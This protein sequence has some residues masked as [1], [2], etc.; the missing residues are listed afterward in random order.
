MS[1]KIVKRNIIIK[2]KKAYFDYTFIDTYTAGIILT[3]TEIKSIRN[4]NASLVDTFCYIK[5]KGLWMKNSYI[6][7]Y[8]KH[9]YVSHDERRL[10]KLLLNKREIKKL[11]SESKVP[12]ITI[13]P[14]KMFINDRGLCK[15]E[16]ALCKGN[17]EYDKR[18]IKK[19]K[20]SKREID[21]LIKSF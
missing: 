2:N 9:G 5:D 11:E 20:D 14:I 7:Q 4:G 10:R 15:V 13:I 16:I 3:G 6:A 8:E 1:K 17:K 18:E 12:G 19:E 21:R